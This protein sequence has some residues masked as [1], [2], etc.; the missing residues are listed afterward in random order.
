MSCDLTSGFK[1]GCR[2]NTGGTKRIFVANFNATT[3][4]T[5]DASNV[6]TAI[7]PVAPDT[8]EYFQYDLQK[9]TAELMEEQT[10]TPE[11]ETIGYVPTINFIFNKLDTPKRNEL[12]LL[13]RTASVVIVED[14]NGRYWIVGREAGLDMT[15]STR[16]TGINITD[17]NGSSVSLVGAESIP[18]QE[19]EFAAFSAYISAVQ[20]S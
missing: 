11:N 1:L 3:D 16:G 13:A 15:T 12:L 19:V 5:E 7:T 10:M 4:Y 8:I 17:R 20:I 9:N 18:F 2:D 14:R 6:V